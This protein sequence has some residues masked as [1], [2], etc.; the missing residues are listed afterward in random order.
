MTAESS[1]SALSSQSTSGMI[2]DYRPKQGTPSAAI[3]SPA[4]YRTEAGTLRTQVNALGGDIAEIHNQATRDDL[5]TRAAVKAKRGVPT[6]LQELAVERGM[7][8]SDIARLVGV[9]VSAVRKWRTGGD[10]TPEKRRLLAQLAAF[11][12]LLEESSI[13]DPAQW[14]E[15]DLALPAEYSVRAVELY[16]SGHMIALLEIAGQRRDPAHVLDE[17]DPQWR[18]TRRSDIEVFTAA[19]GQLAFRERGGSR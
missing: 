12:D 18:D 11:L 7:A 4:Y 3:A 1:H 17:I 5:R 16:A 9:S 15:M 8:W 13:E 19:D 14:L 6:L 2:R 10:A